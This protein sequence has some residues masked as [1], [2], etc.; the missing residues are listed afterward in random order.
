MWPRYLNT[1]QISNEMVIKKLLTQY[2]IYGSAEKLLK[3]GSLTRYGSSY[4]FLRTPKIKKFANI[5]IKVY[6]D[7]I[8]STSV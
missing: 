6:E 4:E 7:E 5:S 2:L 3:W 8:F 1:L